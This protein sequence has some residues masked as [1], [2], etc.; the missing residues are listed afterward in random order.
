MSAIAPVARRLLERTGDHP[1]IS[2]YFDLDPERFATAPA[3]ASQARSLID[4]A[5]ELVKGLHDTLDHDERKTLEADLERLDAYLQSD[6]LPVS[7]ARALAVFASGADDLFETVALGQP[8]ESAVIVRRTPYVEPLVTQPAVGGWCAV[9]VSTRD[10]EIYMGRGDR[11]TGHQHS[12]HYVRGHS[13]ADFTSGHSDDQDIAGHLIQVARQLHRDW[14][15]GRF[16]TL[17]LGGPV[18]AVAGL[19]RELPNDLRHAV[20]EE[21]LRVDPSAITDADLVGAVQEILG[22]EQ[23]RS[24]EEVLAEFT[25]RLA[26]AR[27]RDDAR[28]VAGPEATR[29]ALI[30]RR[31]ATLLL[32]RE[33]EGP[34]REEAVHQAILQDAEVIAFREPVPELGPGREIGALLRF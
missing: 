17:L 13:Q 1:I 16:A 28:A 7:D 3:R 4:K 21:R 25:E 15:V 34:Q 29:E 9:L 5:R 8:T 33:F 11:I 19:E 32:A 2:L 30:E 24:H 18:E 27:G 10:A 6:E 12:E 31:V 26:A 20:R 14:Q 23:E 22:D